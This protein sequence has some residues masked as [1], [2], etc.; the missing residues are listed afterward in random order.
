MHQ[1]LS[2]FWVRTRSKPFSVRATV[3]VL[4]KRPPKNR[5]KAANAGRISRRSQASILSA[6][7]R[8][9]TCS[10]DIALS[11]KRKLEDF[12]GVLNEGAV[13]RLVYLAKEVTQHTE[14]V[15]CILAGKRP[16]Q[17]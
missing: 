4:V 3:V 12:R 6:F 2:C 11:L 17:L 10:I 5:S 16:V 14:N 13:G 7:D 15:E 1:S 9:P 8:K